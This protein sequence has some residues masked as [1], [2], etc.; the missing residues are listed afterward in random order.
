MKCKLLSVFFTV[1]FLINAQ[2]PINNYFSVPLSQY[3]DVTGPIDHNPTGSNAVWDFGSLTSSVVNIDTYAAPTA[4]EVATYPGTT[5]VFTIT[6]DA[7]NTS[8]AFFK[9]DGSDISLTGANN[10]EL[11][12][13]YN[14]DNAFVG[15]YPLTF[16]SAINVDNIAGELQAQGQ[17]SNYT[18]TITVDVDAYG[19][20]AFEVV[21]QG[22]YSGDVTRIL[23][24]Q[25]ISFTVGGI[26]P[27]TATIS[28]YNYY[29]DA[30]GALV[31]R[32][33]DGIISVPSLNINIPISSAEALVTNTLS[34]TNTAISGSVKIYPNPAQDIL[35]IDLDNLSDFQ[36]ITIVDVNGRVVLT[37]NAIERSIDIKTLETGFYTLTMLTKTG[38]IV[39]KFIKQ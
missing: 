22:T 14:T 17:S 10:P 6:D 7:M 38:T 32:S 11:T 27:G 24:V 25:D 19:S 3:V 26:F 13:D 5:Q 20:L 28:N 29:K 1:P 2:S 12:I 33:S 35:H 36:T 9:V 8:V 30:D 18:G 21:G 16:G 31:F 15:S 34:I 37:S 4:T 23:T 39:K